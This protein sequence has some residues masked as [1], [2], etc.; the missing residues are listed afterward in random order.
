MDDVKLPKTSEQKDIIELQGNNVYIYILI[1]NIMLTL[2]CMIT[3]LMQL[4]D[5]SLLL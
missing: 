1:N 3:K 2:L 4:C 5:D